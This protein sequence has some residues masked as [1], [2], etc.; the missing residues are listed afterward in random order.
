MFHTESIH[1]LFGSVSGLFEL[2][3]AS[4][5]IR[6]PRIVKLA[7]ALLRVVRISEESKPTCK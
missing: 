6:R 7:D 1:E 2:Q 4:I 5:F 3:E